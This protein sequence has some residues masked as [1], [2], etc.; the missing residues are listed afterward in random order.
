MV[1]SVSGSGGTKPLPLLSIGSNPSPLV[2][3]G[4]QVSSLLIPLL[5]WTV[6]SSLELVDGKFLPS[7]AAVLELSLI[8]I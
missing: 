3:S 7:P 2:R 8:H 1:A 4:L 6:I 5:L